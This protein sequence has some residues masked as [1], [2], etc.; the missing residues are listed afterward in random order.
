[1]NRKKS[2]C[3]YIWLSSLSVETFRFKDDTPV[4]PIRWSLTLLT[5]RTVEEVSAFGAGYFDDSGDIPNQPGVYSTR[6][7][8][9]LVLSLWL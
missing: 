7:L 1:M 4:N 6:T 2:G 3:E 8:T 5:D 9:H